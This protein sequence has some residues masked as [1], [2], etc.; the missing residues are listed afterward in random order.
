MR[1]VLYSVVANRHQPNLYIYIPIYIPIYI[2][3]IEYKGGWRTPSL[4]VPRPGRPGRR[5]HKNT[6]RSIA[7]G[8]QRRIDYVERKATRVLLQF[9]GENALYISMV[10]P[11][12]R[13][14]VA[15]SDAPFLSWPASVA[16][17]GGR[18]GWARLCCRVDPPISRSLSGQ[19][20]KK[21]FGGGSGG[22]GAA[23]RGA[24]IYIMC[25]HQRHQ[26]KGV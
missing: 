12:R 1:G 24:R 15:S 4:E 20:I 8:L 2:S 9:L 19:T 5:A 6:P 21:A 22:R 23:G 11:A 7:D 26:A 25:S 14:L 16:R 3:G 10:P 17:R 18:W 13:Q